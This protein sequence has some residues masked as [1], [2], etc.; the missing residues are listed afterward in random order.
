[1]SR[2]ERYEQTVKLMDKLQA[3]GKA[4]IIRPQIPAISKFEQDSSK[5]MELYRHG[6]TLMDRRLMELVEFSSDKSAQTASEQA[7]PSVMLA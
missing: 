7:A 2:V 4:F 1:M 5:R 6:Y 3:E